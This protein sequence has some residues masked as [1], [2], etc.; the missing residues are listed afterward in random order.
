[1]N[2]NDAP[3]CPYTN[4]TAEQCAQCPISEQLNTFWL[5][6]GQEQQ[7]LVAQWMIDNETTMNKQL[8]S[9]QMQSIARVT[10]TKLS[11][12]D[13]AFEMYINLRG[14]DTIST[15]LSVLYGTGYVRA[16]TNAEC[17]HVMQKHGVQLPDSIEEFL[18]DV[19]DES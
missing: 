7:E 8:T 4:P 1:M 17:T 2:P 9:D 18:K 13:P 3:R 5:E 12:L 14:Y 15:L 16:K 10:I 11:V 6:Y 19:Q